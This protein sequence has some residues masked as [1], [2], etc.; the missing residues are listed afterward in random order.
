MDD[1]IK[2]II[3]F[4]N[5]GGII[6]TVNLDHLLPNVVVGQ[7]MTFDHPSISMSLTAKVTRVSH[8]VFL[9]EAQSLCYI[10]VEVADR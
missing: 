5:S 2:T 3:E 1:N 6:R 4:K 7:D 10:D 8:V 9:N